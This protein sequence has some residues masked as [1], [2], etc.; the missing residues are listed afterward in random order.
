MVQ[1]HPGLGQWLR[2]LASDG[3]T[4]ERVDDRIRKRGR[5]LT[6]AE[7]EFFDAQRPYILARLSS[8]TVLDEPPGVPDEEL[9]LPSGDPDDVEEAEEAEKEEEEPVEAKADEG[10]TAEHWLCGLAYQSRDPSTG[11]WVLRWADERRSREM[12]AALRRGPVEPPAIGY[13]LVPTVT[14][15]A[16]PVV[17]RPARKGSIR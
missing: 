13:A 10:P 15:T 4:F 17:R 11:R 8:G 12:S 6:P 14:E 9:D 1:E 2:A 5:K 7:H 3:V 16:A